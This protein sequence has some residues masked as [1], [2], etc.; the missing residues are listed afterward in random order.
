MQ[1][2]KAWL[3]RHGESTANTGIISDA[4]ADVI[5]SAKG[6]MQAEKVAEEIIEQP[7]LIIT[8][9]AKRAQETTNF[10]IQAWPDVR[11]TIWPIQEL[12]YLS[13]KRYAQLDAAERV[14]AKEDYWQRAD[15]F[16]CDGDNAESFA[17]F[18]SRV[19]DFKQRLNNKTGFVVVVGHGQF[20]KA[21]QLSL[22]EEFSA[23]ANSMRRFREYE[24]AKPMANCEIMQICFDKT[25][26]IIKS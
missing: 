22:T 17:N 25:K 26:V 10:I 2:L 4:P 11:L 16:Y 24:A 20:F 19:Q 3:I 7:N 18:I 14:K 5:L 12:I 15:P 9:L 8:S 23:T 21:Y 1:E 6:K 13:P